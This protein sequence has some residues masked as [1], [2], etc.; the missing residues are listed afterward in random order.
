LQQLASNEAAQRQQF[1]QSQSDVLVQQNTFV[2]QQQYQSQNAN[3][4]DAHL[5]DF[6]P[7]EHH[8]PGKQQSASST[9]DDEESLHVSQFVP[10]LFDA[11]SRADDGTPRLSH[12]VPTHHM[13]ADGTP[14]MTHLVPTHMQ[15]DLQVGAP[16]R[17]VSVEGTPRMTHLVP[18]QMEASEGTPRMSHWMPTHMEVDSQTGV[19]ARSVYELDGTPRMS[20]LMPDLQKSSPKGFQAMGFQAEGFRASSSV[21]GTP[22]MSHLMPSLDSAP[23]PLVNQQNVTFSNSSFFGGAALAPTLQ[24]NRGTP[25]M[26]DFTPLEHSP[27][28]KQSWAGYG[29]LSDFTPLEHSRNIK[30]SSAG[31]GGYGGGFASGPNELAHFTPIEHTLAGNDMNSSGPDWT[32]RMSHLVP[33]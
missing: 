15:R 9:V 2:N 14:R 31:Y 18:T 32:P 10:S 27:D 1:M 29:V 24:A 20:H 3:D 4:S 19:P 8:S 13:E 7:I 17:P 25:R 11:S 21:E 6:V 23:G 16:G 28:I 5:Q 30:P 12:L 33:S 26:S 22:R